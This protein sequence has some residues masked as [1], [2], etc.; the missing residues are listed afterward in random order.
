MQDKDKFKKPPDY[1]MRKSEL[2]SGMRDVRERILA[3]ASSLPENQQDEICVG[4]WSSREMLAHLAGWDET[5]IQA[6]NE[7]LAGNL[8]SFY[9]HSDK[10]WATYNAKL[11]SEYNRDQFEELLSLVRETHKNLLA[12]IS[13]LPANEIWEDRGIRARGW[14]VT[15]GRLLEVET[16]DEEEHYSQLKQFLEAGVES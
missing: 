8:P 14:I 4:K 13:D 7:I 16:E 9:K 6:T 3:L 5:N 10:D 15:I 2:I 1:E 12:L 11:V